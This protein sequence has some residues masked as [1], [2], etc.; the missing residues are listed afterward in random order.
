MDMHVASLEE[1]LRSVRIENSYS[2]SFSDLLEDFYSP[3]ISV[4]ASYHGYR[5]YSRRL[6]EERWTNSYYLFTKDD[7]RRCPSDFSRF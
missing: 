2:S 6:S 1:G 5:D 3:A 7:R 4:S